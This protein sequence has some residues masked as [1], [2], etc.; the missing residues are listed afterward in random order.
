MR[1]INF[2]ALRRNGEWRRDLN[3]ELCTPLTKNI[4][5]SWSKVFESD[6]FGSFET[7]T[8][9]AIKKVVKEVE[10][11]APLGLKDRTRCQGELCLEEA[12]IALNKT[13]D[14]VKDTMNAEQKEVSR[15]IAP[16]VQ[17][18]LQDGYETSYAE[19]GTGS[20]ARQKV[21]CT[22]HMICGSTC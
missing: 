8:K 19:R 6:L 21:S 1:L 10:D 5:S 4:A 14:L 20:V 2:V 15:V 7:S 12:N 22:I 11:T 16:Y 13:L 17:H 18:Q 9:A 3:V